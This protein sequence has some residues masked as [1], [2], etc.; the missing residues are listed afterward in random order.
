MAVEFVQTGR[1]N[2]AEAH[3]FALEQTCG[4]TT[5]SLS[6]EEAVNR[7][8]QPTKAASRIS[9]PIAFQ[10]NC[11]TFHTHFILEQIG[12]PNVYP[13]VH[14]GKRYIFRCYNLCTDPMA[15][16]RYASYCTSP[17]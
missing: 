8:G 1:E 13:G 2:I 16:N 4:A 9:L 10:G 17:V 7:N 15:M 14:T 5:A 6:D 11:L 12:D 3:A